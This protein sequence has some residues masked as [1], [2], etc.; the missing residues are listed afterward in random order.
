MLLS[1]DNL[2]HAVTSIN[3]ALG[4]TVEDVFFT[5]LPMSHVYGINTGVLLPMLLGAT[6]VVMA[7]FRSGAAL[8]AIAAHRATILNGVPSMY[9]RMAAE[10]KCSPRDLACV[11][12][13]TI[14]GAACAN[15][16]EYRRVLH[17]SLRVIYGATE[18]PIVAMTSASDP[19]DTAITGVG[20]F[21]DTIDARIVDEAGRPVERGTRGEILCQSPGAMLG[22]LGDPAATARCIDERGW[23]HMGDIAYEDDKGYVHIVG[24]KG[25]V[26]N[27]GGYKVAPAE[28]ERAYSGHPALGACCAMGFPHH[29]LGQQIVLFAEVRPGCSPEGSLRDYAK[30]RLAKF[31]LPDQ[32]IVLEAMPYLPN[33]KIDKAAL[34]NLRERR[35][36]GGIA[37]GCQVGE[38]R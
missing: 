32:V 17:C 35:G 8:D 24:R 18:C 26:I 15:L 6:S 12:Q 30:G 7:K 4:A 23:V 16:D 33:G 38:N 36:L 11:S 31:K 19:L 20:R 27:R 14:A 5:A 2:I 1:E 9:R 29:D 37:G 34:R 13:G 25:D 28:V 21:N 22:Y 3:K 10:Q